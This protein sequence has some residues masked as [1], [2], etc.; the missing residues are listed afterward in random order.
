MIIAT[1]IFLFVVLPLLESGRID[2][3]NLE[4]HEKRKRR[5]GKA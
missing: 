5:N 3:Q 4:Y 1:I 2:Q